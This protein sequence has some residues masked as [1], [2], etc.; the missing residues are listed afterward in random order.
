MLTARRVITGRTYEAR[1]ENYQ[2]LHKAATLVDLQAH[3]SLKASWFPHNLNEAHYK[4]NLL[5]RMLRINPLA[6]DPL[7]VR[8][9]FPKLIDGQ[10]NVQVST[11]YAL[12]RD[13]VKKD[14]LTEVKVLGIPIS[15]SF[16]TIVR[17]LRWLPYLKRAWENALAPS[18]FDSVWN[19][20]NI[21][22]KQVAQY[23]KSDPSAPGL[24]FAKTPAQLRTMLARNDI[25]L[26][27]ALEGAHS[28]EGEKTW[29]IQ[30]K[31]RDPRERSAGDN[32]IVRKDVM[33]N[34]QTLYERGVA[35]M[36]LAHYYPNEVT[37][38]V[39]SYPERA[40]EKIT[41]ERWQMMWP[42]HTRGLTELG[43]DVVDWMIGEGM[44]I[45]LSHVSPTARMEI[46]N[47]VDERHAGKPGAVLASH[48]GLQAMYNHPYNLADWEIRW[49]S[50]HGGVVGVMFSNYWHTGR[51]GVK[52]G[53]G[54]LTD[55]I[56]HLIAIGGEG[57]V[58]FGSDFDG[59]SDPPD[60]IADASQW[61]KL[62]RHLFSQ[63]KMTEGEEDP[64]G[65]VEREITRKYSDDAIRQ[66][67]G[68]N[69]LQ[70]I[71]AGW[72]SS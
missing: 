25:A 59:F 63:Y 49:L 34:L 2:H 3:P 4:P 7:T 37:E 61:M 32:D 51:E 29:A 45:D 8:T 41:Y 53:L 30:Q 14:L 62:T 5:Q 48:I 21:I 52:L 44:I 69:A 43:K 13:A 20:L 15:M 55:A 64:S 72:G 67:L 47:I 65:A 33:G 58:A 70:T 36:G 40:L 11:A 46:Y 50:D 10:V 71:L 19:A 38:S 42:D 9:S 68:G 26:V 22:E 23:V 35:I 28:L 56:D 12:E 6:F 17:T 57:V 18:Y 60:E 1:R 39:F 16:Y 54:Y 66:F 24:G 31:V 27:H